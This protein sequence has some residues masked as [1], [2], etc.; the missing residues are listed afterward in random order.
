MQRDLPMIRQLYRK[1]REKHETALLPIK[2]AV[3]GEQQM[4]GV[5]VGSAEGMQPHWKAFEGLVDLYLFEPHPQSFETLRLQISSSPHADKLH[6]IPV[7]LSGQSGERTL[8]MLNS[9]TGSSLLPVD[10]DSEYA[11]PDNEY[12][13]PLREMRVH[14][15]SLTDVLDENGLRGP[16]IIKLD[17]QGAELEILRG[18][19]RQRLRHL[20]LAEVEVNIAGGVTSNQSLYR[21]SPTWAQVDEFFVANQMHLLDIGVARAYRGH[22]ADADHYQRE[23]FKVYRN[24][25]TLSAR[26]W[27]ADV[28]YVREPRALLEEGDPGAVRRLVIAL[29]GY[30]FFADA[31]ALMEK[32]E[33]AGLFQAD[34]AVR[35]KAAIEAWHR[36]GTLPWH[37]RG[38]L[39]NQMRR[40]LRM[41]RV[42][43]LVRWKQYMW[44]DYPNG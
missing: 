19:D 2:R 31:Y 30:R 18:L 35:V 41:T 6:V 9:R 12:V 3:L 11:H 25:P 26:V 21:G 10:S 23:V 15:R 16:D 29:C 13:H 33:E 20:L 42:S 1:R 43:Q 28:V 14:T 36:A 27:E 34:A 5:D 22:G 38:F 32:A 40:V 4:I 44:F 7:A 37:G 39:W 8:Y 17:V 24:S